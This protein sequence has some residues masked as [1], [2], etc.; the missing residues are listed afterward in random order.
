VIIAL[1]LEEEEKKEKEK[2]REERR[3]SHYKKRFLLSL[4]AEE[5]QVCQHHIPCESLLNQTAFP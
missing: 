1:L 2:E 5:K 4:G 3:Y